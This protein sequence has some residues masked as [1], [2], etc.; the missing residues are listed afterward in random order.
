MIREDNHR[1]E[2]RQISPEFKA[3]IK[4]EPEAYRVYVE[5]SDLRPNAEIG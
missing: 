5:D 2:K 1:A 3:G 4:S